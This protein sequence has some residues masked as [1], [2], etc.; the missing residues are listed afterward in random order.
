MTFVLAG[1]LCNISARGA[2]ANLPHRLRVGQK[3]RLD[4][5]FPFS[6][7]VWMSYDGEVVRTEPSMSGT[8]VAVKYI[9]PRPSFVEGE[10]DR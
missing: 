8:S 5:A 10:I 1:R 7:S 2:L 3:V 6:K 9:D 4:I